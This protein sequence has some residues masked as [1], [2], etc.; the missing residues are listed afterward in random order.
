MPEKETTGLDHDP[1]SLLAETMQHFSP[2]LIQGQA[3]L[4]AAVMQDPEKKHALASALEASLKT[5]ILWNTSKKAPSYL[6]L[7]LRA[8]TKFDDKLILDNKIWPATKPYYR[9]IELQQSLPQIE[10][11]LSN[12]PN[13]ERKKILEEFD[14]VRAAVL[15][16][17]RYFYDKIDQQIRQ[18]LLVQLVNLQIEGV[19]YTHAGLV[20]E[21]KT[22]IDQQKKEAIVHDEQ[23][24]LE[25]LHAAMEKDPGNI[26][27]TT[28]YFQHSFRIAKTL[29]NK[30][31][32]QD[33]I[34]QIAQLVTTKQ[35]TGPQEVEKHFGKTIR[36]AVDKLVAETAKYLVAYDRVIDILSQT[37][38]DDKQKTAP[39]LSQK[40]ITR[41]EYA[42]YRPSEAAN[43][44]R[45]ESGRTVPSNIYKLHMPGLA[46]IMMRMNPQE[47]RQLKP[48]LQ[49]YKPVAGKQLIVYNFQH[50][51]ITTSNTPYEW[52]SR[53][54]RDDHSAEE[55]SLNMLSFSSLAYASEDAQ[56]NL[57]ITDLRW[58][59]KE[60]ITR[61]TQTKAQLASNLAM[62]VVE[63]PAFTKNYDDYC[64]L[65]EDSDLDPANKN[66]YLGRLSAFQE[67]FSKAWVSKQD[68]MS[69]EQI[70]T[71]LLKDI[72]RLQ[73]KLPAL[74]KNKQQLE[75]MLASVQK[76]TA[77]GREFTVQAQREQRIRQSLQGINELL[78][79]LTPQSSESWWIQ[80]WMYG[81]IRWFGKVNTSSCPLEQYLNIFTNSREF[82]E[83]DDRR[84]AA[85]WWIKNNGVKIVGAVAWMFAAAALAAPSGGWSLFVY[86]ASVQGIL[87]GS[88]GAL[89]G[90]RVWQVSN[91]LL[92]KWVNRASGATIN[93]RP[94]RYDDPTDIEQFLDGK[95][96][97]GDLAEG[98][99][100]EYA[101]SAAMQL[102]V[103]RVASYL[104]ANCGWLSKVKGTG[105]EKYSR[106][107]AVNKVWLKSGLWTMDMA[108]KRLAIQMMQQ[109]RN[110]STTVGRAATG[111]VLEEVGDDALDNLAQKAWLPGF[112]L[113]LWV[114]RWLQGKTRT[115]G[116]SLATAHGLSSRA[117]HVQW[118]TA[119]V[120]FDY[121]P[122]TNIKQLI[123]HYTTQGYTTTTDSSG[124]IV[125]TGSDPDLLD[126]QIQITLQASEMPH[127]IRML[128]WRLQ[129]IDPSIRLVSTTAQETPVFTIDGLDVDAQNR[130]LT[131]LQRN[132][133]VMDEENGMMRC[134]DWKETFL[135]DPIA[136]TRQ[137]RT[138]GALAELETD[139]S[140][141]TI[142][143]V[144][145]MTPTP[146]P[147]LPEID[148]RVE[149]DEKIQAKHEKKL[150]QMKRVREQQGVSSE[151]IPAVAD[152]QTIYDN[153]SLAFDERTVSFNTRLGN[154]WI[155]LITDPETQETLW[156][157]HIAEGNG[158]FIDGKSAA[159]AQREKALQ[160]LQDDGKITPD[161][162][163]ILSDWG[164]MG[165][166]TTFLKA[167]L[168][169]TA[170][171][172]LK[173]PGKRDI[174][175]GMDDTAD[176]IA[177]KNKELEQKK[178]ELKKKLDAKDKESQ[179]KVDERKRIE[180]KQQKLE[181][182]R[183]NKDKDIRVEQTEQSKLES[184]L[185]GVETRIAEIN[186]EIGR[187][188][189]RNVWEK[190]TLW[191]RKTSLEAQIKTKKNL[192]LSLKRER[193]AI[194]DK[195]DAEEKNLATV[196]TDIA[197]IK[198]EKNA[199]GDET[200]DSDIQN[201]DRDIASLE[202]TKKRLQK[203]LDDRDTLDSLASWAKLYLPK[204]E[205]GV[206]RVRG[207]DIP[208]PTRTV[209]NLI[210][211]LRWIILPKN[212][213]DVQ[214]RLVRILVDNVVVGLFDENLFTLVITR[215]RYFLMD[216][217]AA[218]TGWWRDNTEQTNIF[219]WTMGL[220]SP[221]TD[222]QP[223]I[224]GLWLLKKT[225]EWILKLWWAAADTGAKVIDDPLGTAWDVIVSGA[226]RL[227]AYAKKKWIEIYDKATGKKKT[228]EQI[229]QELWE[230]EL[231]RRRN[232]WF[233]E[234]WEWTLSPSEY[235]SKLTES[236]T[237]GLW[238]SSPLSREIG[239]DSEIIDLD[240]IHEQVHQTQVLDALDREH[241]ERKPTK[242]W[243]GMTM[244]LPAGKRRLTSVYGHRHS[245]DTDH[246]WRDFRA[247]KGTTVS[248][249]KDGVVIF[250][251]HQ[252]VTAV[253]VP[254]DLV[255]RFT[256]IGVD[257]TKWRWNYVIVDHG[258]WVWSLYAHLDSDVVKKWDTVKKGQKIAESGNSGGE[259][260][261][262]AMAPHLHFEMRENKKQVSPSEYFSL[263]KK[264]GYASK[265]EEWQKTVEKPTDDTQVSADTAW[266]KETKKTKKKTQTW[267]VGSNWNS[268]RSSS[269]EP[270]STPPVATGKKRYGGK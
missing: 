207:I 217:I 38:L 249:I 75:A 117:F 108:Q 76:R 57:V 139:V 102:G 5:Q 150:A 219:K 73:A 144:V 147:V 208:L 210:A 270:V 216:M 66:G 204:L 126:H 1:S 112:S 142:E 9:R 60:T 82:Y 55:Q 52:G 258:G 163:R 269:P 161:Q 41:S 133:R 239:W 116:V 121:D 223:A 62:N 113:L 136:D 212:T 168:W 169:K 45:T 91:E 182:D 199:L 29:A 107:M 99:L 26:A 125:L 222:R 137:W 101:M 255:K 14:A 123:T 7:Q 240:A 177:K 242:K 205:M 80:T 95:L 152:L 156:N 37:Q 96:K 51:V 20:K 132:Y 262:K 170:K 186:A 151:Q 241:A 226:E 202:W 44:R 264:S 68:V 134:T 154:A 231:E 89:V 6:Q 31:I 146:P 2:D 194:Q 54:L 72:P 40:D 234:Q 43:N 135:L 23:L 46:P 220:L 129:D 253:D 111:E 185:A 141:W 261:F 61:T 157:I 235:L 56:G 190:T 87:V 224:P 49:Q 228:E 70:A 110:A 103:A 131:E 11:L 250:A 145:S 17:W 18:D 33:T 175:E 200:T 184:D 10:T 263:V 98:M 160:A 193:K 149:V 171:K 27:L 245:T 164:Y 266:K 53:S 138:M 88:A 195:I 243:T 215:P 197:R 153:G 69:G 214:E 32:E 206:W 201:I 167:K 188:D 211:F 42:A 97:A 203:E 114:R 229:R 25:R 59:K 21:L 128:E 48:F 179:E 238:D 233:F 247:E 22:S 251:G 85:W 230:A 118:N 256:S 105:M 65:S 24:H 35:Y 165:P 232:A 189:L 34:M 81:H 180:S 252:D 260:W 237:L 246:K 28:Q 265:G 63:D 158:Q 130:A 127:K 178:Q 79:Q 268:T 39:V 248:A 78:Y 84:E 213:K 259:V 94:V 192:I 119:Q 74:Q 196:D 155:P 90:S 198:T 36:L 8:W 257:T 159:Y 176:A 86:M 244:P 50:K 83:N 47:E 181:W 13:Q 143:P 225:Y 120:V 106:F 173:T 191:V 100:F 16:E 140:L 218:I 58:N 174:E 267:W 67:K 209:E 4:E 183:D 19:S 77:H 104:S 3:R 236:L 71:T 64:S 227:W 187:W 254:D 115:W 12:I 15:K 162:R 92:R 30:Q 148:T 122:R 166:T 93:G 172:L 221:H 109:A 124:N